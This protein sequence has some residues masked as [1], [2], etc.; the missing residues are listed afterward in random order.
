M[1]EFKGV[2]GLSTHGQGHFSSYDA[3][4]I[5]DFYSKAYSMVTRSGE[6][7]D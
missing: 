5:Y 3:G 2:S 1:G 6:Y 7:E 4:E